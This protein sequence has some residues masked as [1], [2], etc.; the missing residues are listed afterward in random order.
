VPNSASDLLTE[1]VH[2]KYEIAPGR[3]AELMRALARRRLPDADAV[4]ALH[5]ALCF[6]RAYPDSAE[7][8]TLA[9]RLLAAFPDRPD[10][11]RF[12]KALAD[13]GIGGT[14]IDFR[15]FWRMAIRLVKRWPEALEIVW[16]EFEN[17]DKL[18]DALHL[19]VPYAETPALDTLG[20][21]PREWLDT[22]RK[23]DET[24]ATFLIRRYDAVRGSTPVK[25]KLFEELDVPIRLQP[26]PATPA[27]GRETWKRAP[28]AIRRQPPSRNR[29]ASF[30]KTVLDTR[31]KVRNATPREARELIEL[32]NACMVT[33]HRDLLV[34]LH[35]DENDVR[36]LDCGNGLQFA[37][38]GTRPD[39]R[40]VLESVYG[41]L[42]LRSGVAIGYV[43]C[44][45]FFESAEV[46]Y[47]VFETFRG[48]DT[49]QTFAAFLAVVRHVFGT[50]SFALDP[51]Q[52]GHDNEEGQKSGAWWFYYKLGF[53]PHDAG[54]KAMIRQELARL[55][56]EPGY[57]TSLRRL[58]ELASEY[59]YFHLGKPRRDVLG[60]IGLGNIGLHSSHLLA[61][62]FGADRERGIRECAAETA[63]LLGLRSELSKGE[64][65]AWDRWSP[66][67][68][69]LP[70]VK[71]WTPQQ[72]RALRDVVRAKGGRRESEYVRRFDAHPKLRK[73]MLELAATGP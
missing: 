13:T 42:A 70:G 4:E 20:Y 69:A 58:N 57:R 1:L 36:L 37:C 55:E 33:R 21:G 65:V 34:F 48:A 32:A 38:I 19:L 27:R 54:V 47:N 26:G 16:P 39:R 62:R 63:K 31:V 73:A 5:E 67:V 10:L 43:L 40:L 12:R 35:A 56:H 11:R 8:C 24:D 53:R 25:E 2:L 66:L 61:T 49:G 23:Q 3:K 15:Y 59:M 14:T 17:K 52:L 46:A 71:R 7:V 9:G 50:D 6:F 68:L 64:R 41:F 18:L 45:A 29:P 22:L 44:S 72:R 28:V 51:Y 30:R 60:H